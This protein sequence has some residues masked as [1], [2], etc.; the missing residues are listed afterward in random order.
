[1]TDRERITRPLPITRPLEAFDAAA[2]ALGDRAHESYK[3]R[4]RDGLNEIQRETSGLLESLLTTPISER[5]E[6]R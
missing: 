6:N 5:E 4:L 1:M 3:G 2:R